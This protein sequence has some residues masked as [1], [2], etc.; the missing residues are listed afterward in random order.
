[1]KFLIL[2]FAFTAALFANELI[3]SG[4]VTSDNQKYITSRYMGYVTAIN[5]K[6]GDEVRKGDVLYV[7]DS[8]EIDAQRLQVELQVEQA[9]L[10]LSMHQNQF[11]NVDLNYQRHK[12]L[13]D[14]DMVSKYELERL[15]LH[16]NNLKDMVAISSKQV[17][18][19]QAQ[20]QVIKNQ[21][22]YLKVKAPNNGFIT[23][24]NIKVGEMA[25]PGMPAMIISSTDDL[26]VVTEV[27]ETEMAKLKKGEKVT[28]IIDSI[29]Y[30]GDGNI[31]AIV[32]ASN[33]MT[34]SFKVKVDFAP[35]QTVYPGMY[36]KVIAPA[37]ET[38][39]GK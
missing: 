35:N 10:A 3:L 23:T 21:Y 1:M 32:P 9:R 30:K 16:R 7:I 12:R 2:F 20:L 5:A 8:K 18:Q 34:H 13:Y 17:R 31:S 36:A 27:S 26:K 33:P 39:N 28:V 22:A 4:S 29:D 11:N 25:M 6:E 24:K 19:A 15:E 38:Q 14:K 37:K